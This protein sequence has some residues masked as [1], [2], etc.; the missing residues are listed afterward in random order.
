MNG[1]LHKPPQLAIFGGRLHCI[2]IENAAEETLLWF[3]RPLLSFQLF[4]W[5]SH[6]QDHTSLSSLTI[7]GTHD[8]SIA[9]P[10]TLWQQLNLGIRFF[11]LRLQLE[12]D[13]LFCAFRSSI[14]RLLFCSFSS[15]MRD[16]FEFLVAQQSETVLISIAQDGSQSWVPPIRFCSA[17]RT[18]IDAMADASGGRFRWYTLSD[19]PDLG[20]VRSRAVLL[21]RFPLPTHVLGSP[22]PLG[23][24]FS[25]WEE[26]EPASGSNLTDPSHTGKVFVLSKFLIPRGMPLATLVRIHSRKVVDH[27]L[28]SCRR[29]AGTWSVAFC[30]A[31]CHPTVRSEETFEAVHVAA[32]AHSKLSNKWVDGM[33]IVLA[34]FLRNMSSS[35]WDQKI[36]RKS[37][38]GIV[39][40]DFP[41]E[42]ES[43]DAVATLIEMNFPPWLRR[44]PGTNGVGRPGAGGFG[45]FERYR[46]AVDS[47][48][49]E[50]SVGTPT[51][52]KRGPDDTET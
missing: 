42:D 44:S 20:T 7:P 19:I 24:D 33:N 28:R 4:S 17:V 41:D 31:H 10:L 32:G 48:A 52:A 14:D 34:R 46:D 8:Y 26:S 15:I 18:E 6:Y 45:L 22:L 12:A 35:G 9:Q 1:T 36:R 16:V 38:L 23:V 29:E 39:L 51:G 30:S 27:M 13:G 3:S 11:D 40:M 47:E 43:D 49:E 25:N 2:F 37:G 5:M 21:R 50:E